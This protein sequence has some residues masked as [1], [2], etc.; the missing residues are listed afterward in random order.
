MQSSEI[1]RNEILDID[2]RLENFWNNGYSSHFQKSIICKCPNTTCHGFVLQGTTSCTTCNIEIC[3]ECR[4]VHQLNHQCNVDTVKTIKMIQSE[5]KP[6][7]GCGIQIHRIQGCYQMWCTQCHTTFHYK[8]GQVLKEPIHNPH[9][10]EWVKTLP[11]QTDQECQELNVI[12]L[13]N[14][15]SILHERKSTKDEI[16]LVTSSRKTYDHLMG[17]KHEA[18]HH[19]QKINDAVKLHNTRMKFILSSSMTTLEYKKLLYTRFKQQGKLKDVVAFIETI[20]LFL[21]LLLYHFVHQTMTI[22]EIKTA[23]DDF[24]A[25]IDHESNR[26]VKLY[27]SIFPNIR[28]IGYRLQ[29]EQNSGREYIHR[30]VSE[31]ITDECDICCE[32]G[33]VIKCNKCQYTCCVNCF[34]QYTFNS[35]N[36]A[37]CIECKIYFDRETLINKLGRNWY[38]K[39]YKLY[40]YELLF[41][42]EELQIEKSCEFYRLQQEREK[43]HKEWQTLIYKEFNEKFHRNL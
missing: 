25:Q 43:L 11:H 1:K 27:N 12:S 9:Y 23:L 42:R 20:V 32:L 6:C 3:L 39:R 22:S 29:T 40:L 26:L 30:H 18:D 8:T 37:S 24:V 35:I 34:E 33:R 19:L 4:D 17:I 31:K 13:E 36:E 14:L 5:T 28:I 15:K 10:I 21:T 2:Y 16:L 38:E 7:P 41:Q